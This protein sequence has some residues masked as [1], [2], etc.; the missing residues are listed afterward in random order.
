MDTP[1]SRESQDTLNKSGDRKNLIDIVQKIPFFSAFD[2]TIL[3][4]I[5]RLSKTRKYQAGDIIILEETY[6]SR[7]HIMINGTVAVTKQNE[8]ITLLDEPG[9]V[10]GELAII[11]GD[12]R[13]ASVK[14]V[15]DAVCLEV[16]ASFIDRLTPEKKANFHRLFYSFII[17]TMARRLRTTTKNVSDIKLDNS[18][19]RQERNQLENENRQLKKE[20]ARLKDEAAL[21]RKE[22]ISRAMVTNKDH[23]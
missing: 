9:D 18:K 3:T 2:R 10:F 7:L 20:N 5:L 6:D 8:I 11:D 15:R 19:L 17:G 21:L 13:S 4:E 14:A 1:S 12:I 23:R 22:N 16:D